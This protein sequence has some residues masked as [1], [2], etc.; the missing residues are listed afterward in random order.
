MTWKLVVAYLGWLLAAAAVALL[1]GSLISEL[2][3]LV[4]VV[5]AGSDGQQRVVEVCLVAGFL[6][7][8]LLP[9]LLR[10]LLLR[11]EDAAASGDDDG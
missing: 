9:F 8:A 7:L 4:G 5:E 11:S 2:A 10:R 3:A 6:W 1:F